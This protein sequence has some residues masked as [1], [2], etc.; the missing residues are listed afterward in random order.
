MMQ[1][2]KQD[3][4]IS[5]SLIDGLNGTGLPLL[6]TSKN[7]YT[8]YFLIDTGASRNYIRQDCL[9]LPEINEDTLFLDV[10]EEYYGIDNVSHE[11]GTCNFRFDLNQH[12]Y[13]ER[14]Q[15]IKDGSALNFPTT[16]GFLHVVGILGTPFLRQYKAMI[17]FAASEISC[18]TPEPIDQDSKVLTFSLKSNIFT[19]GSYREHPISL[20]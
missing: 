9:N 16:D 6:K 2:R 5:V 14:F 7:G 8:L 18:A 3:N 1:K 4:R 19:K 15:I 17:D 13:M 10:R 12:Q 11:A 20:K